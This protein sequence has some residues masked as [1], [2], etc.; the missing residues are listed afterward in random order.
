[1]TCY[2]VKR[3][4]IKLSWLA[5]KYT[6]YLNDRL[7]EEDKYDVGG[8]WYFEVLED[9]SEHV[10]GLKEIVMGLSKPHRA[11]ILRRRSSCS[12]KGVG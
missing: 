5:N 4:S 12:I 3:E 8:R 6:E 10:S 1:M 9:V 11:Q 7:D 2:F